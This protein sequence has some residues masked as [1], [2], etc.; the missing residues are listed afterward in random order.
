MYK[1]LLVD[2][3]NLVRVAFRTMVDYEKHGFYI[4][5]TAQDG[6]EALALYDEMHP[7]LVITDIKMPRMDGIELIRALKERDFWGKIVIM[8]NY[9]DFELVR[10]GMLLGAQDYLLKL[11]ITTEQ[12]V[13]MLLRI[14]TLLDEANRRRL[15]TQ[16]MRVA[17]TQLEQ[18]KKSD[19]WVQ[20]LRGESPVK[21]AKRLLEDGDKS[22]I[23][24]HILRYGEQE[25]SVS[26]SDRNLTNYASMNIV[27]ELLEEETIV[28]GQ[29]EEKW[30][31]AVV[32]GN[33]KEEEMISSSQKL[34]A[35]LTKYLNITVAVLY[36]EPLRE[37]SDLT[38]L[39]GRYRNARQWLF[40]ETCGGVCSL[41]AV[42]N[43]TEWEMDAAKLSA[44]FVELMRNQD[45]ESLERQ[46]IREIEECRATI[47][48]PEQMLQRW[49]VVLD[50]IMEKA[51]VETAHTNW[52]GALHACENVQE[53]Q[54]LLIDLFRRIYQES[55]SEQQSAYSPETR[56]IL[57]Y[58]RQHLEKRITLSELARYV[59]FNETY[60][61][62][63][64]RNQ[65]GMSIVTY[66]NKLKME[67]AAE[68]L[69]DDRLLLKE[70]ATELG[71]SDQFYFNKMFRKHFGVSPSEY[72]KGQKDFTKIE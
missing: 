72:R 55:Q 18:Q 4:C 32:S 49:A 33:K 13:D 54:Q 59:S 37:E 44:R 56:A 39:T 19:Q 26:K 52:G 25:Q 67:R 24:L 20:F 9:D 36:T 40:Y 8:S 11:T 5:A 58:I 68:M 34:Y 41:A 45:L 12:Y 42:P 22:I 62:T 27:T 46:V 70:V 3:E 16:E 61:C 15:E 43:S 50:R 30:L 28:K 31:F 38:K 60:M 17:A 23:F 7:D 10:Q 14:K 2:D 66:I 47:A 21:Q 71:F 57:R 69:R 35:T 51:A 29:L 6:Q 1:I 53:L 65:T 64:F 48:P 63:M